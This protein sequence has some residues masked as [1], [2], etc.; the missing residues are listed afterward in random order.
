M[1]TV[2]QVQNSRGTMITS[3][4][5]NTKGNYGL[6][7]SGIPFDS[8]GIFIHVQGP[9]SDT[10]QTLVDIAAGTIGSEQVFLNNLHV[11]AVFAN[12]V[13]PFYFPVP[14]PKNTRVSARAQSSAASSLVGVMGHLFST[15]FADMS[16]LGKVTT[17]GANTTDSGGTAIDPGAI[18]GTKG[19]WVQIGVT[20]SPIVKLLIAIGGDSNSIRART[21]WLFDIG[22]G[23]AASEQVIRGNIPLIFDDAYILPKTIG[24]FSI[25][26]PTGTRIAVRSQ[27]SN[28]DATDRLFDVILYGIS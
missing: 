22:I 27:C 18:A 9:L 19:S 28:T 14:L 24:P 16:P 12:V 2:E 26:I 4:V 25:S 11:D 1:G 7:S 13:A 6:L 10:K 17:Y 20:T 23:T 21:S 5:A 15:S 8:H 3:G